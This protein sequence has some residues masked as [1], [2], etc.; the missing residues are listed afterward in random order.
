M[1]AVLHCR[2]QGIFPF[3]RI[4][5]YCVT[6]AIAFSVISHSH[7]K[8]DFASNTLSCTA[9]TRRVTYILRGRLRRERC[10]FYYPDR[11]A[12]YCDQR[13]C[14]SVCLSAR[15]SHTPHVQILTTFLYMLPVDVAR[16]FSD[17]N[18]IRYYVMY[19]HSVLSLWW[20]FGVVVTHWFRSTR[21]TYAEP[22]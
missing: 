5:L 13:V 2:P 11:G 20:L 1:H 15:I 4:A 12:K 9:F 17:G 22:G 14:V 7:A 18:A 3:F 6:Q 21:L 10:Y 8:S 19:F 16:F